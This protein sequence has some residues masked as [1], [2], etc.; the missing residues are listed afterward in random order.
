MKKVHTLS[1]LFVTAMCLSPVA[2]SYSQVAISADTL[3]SILIEDWVRAKAYTQD[4]M[5]AM[6]PDKYN[7][8]AT[9]SV[10]TFAQQLL[11]I[12]QSF[13]FFIAIATGQKPDFSTARP[14]ENIASAQTA[15]SVMYF[16]NTGYDAAINGLKNTSAADLM[17]KETFTMDKPYT[18]TRLS[19][20]MKAFEHQTHHRGQTTIYLRLAG[21]KPPDERLF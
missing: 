17:K 2:K 14:L 4:Y 1:L 18:S 11:H 3:K 6:P 10:R 16:V 8:R 5:K 19:W 12:S 9:D 13:S 7:F 15:D 20:F 21:V